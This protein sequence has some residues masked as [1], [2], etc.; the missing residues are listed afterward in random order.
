[1]NNLNCGKS[2]VN[3]FLRRAR[4]LYSYLNIKTDEEYFKLLGMKSNSYRGWYVNGI[5]KIYLFIL[6]LLEED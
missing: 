6:D 4:N 2:D 1:M 3:L 5:R